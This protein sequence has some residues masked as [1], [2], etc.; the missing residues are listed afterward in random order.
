V[1]WVLFWLGFALVLALMYFAPY[2]RR[3]TRRLYEKPASTEGVPSDASIRSAE[4]G[5]GPGYWQSGGLPPP[6]Q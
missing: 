6:T 3:R 4:L 1:G 5:R 2:L